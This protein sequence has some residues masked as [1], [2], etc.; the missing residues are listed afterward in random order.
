MIGKR[1]RDKNKTNNNRLERKSDTTQGKAK[2][3]KPFRINRK[4]N[5][6]N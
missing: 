6:N 2:A 1:T 5:K 4:K 3:L